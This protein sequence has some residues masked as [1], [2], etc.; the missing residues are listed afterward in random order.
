M[1]FGKSWKIEVYMTEGG[2]EPFVEWKDRLDL[3]L[4]MKV[5]ARLNCVQNGN[6]GE[7]RYLSDGVSELKF[8]DGIRVYYSEVKKVIILLLCGGDKNTKRD[9]SKD[10]EKA[11]EYLADYERRKQ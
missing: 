1:I 2:K 10:I 9:Q 8:R 7:R 11:K 3:R 6:F 4:K 5:L